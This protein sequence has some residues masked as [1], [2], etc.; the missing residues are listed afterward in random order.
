MPLV[1]L[2]KWWLGKV[3]H[4]FNLLVEQKASGMRFINFEEI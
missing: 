4:G 2:A 1:G 3:Q